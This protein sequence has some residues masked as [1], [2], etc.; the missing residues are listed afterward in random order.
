MCNGVDDDCDNIVDDGVAQLYWP[1]ADGD[2]FGD[3]LGA[4]VRGCVPPA[5]MVAAAGDCDD[6]D[7]TLAD[8]SC[9]TEIAGG[10]PTFG[11]DVGRTGHAAGFVG[12]GLLQPLWVVTLAGT[13]VEPAAIAG[14][15]VVV[16]ADGSTDTVHAI[17]IATGQPLWSS[18]IDA[19]SYPTAPTVDGD[20]V[21][22][23]RVNSG[24]SDLI[25]LDLVT[26]FEVW[27]TAFTVQW[28]QYWSPLVMGGRVFAAGGY[29]GG[30]YGWDATTGI[31]L[32]YEDTPWFDQWTPAGHDNIVYTHIDDALT[33]RDPLSG[34]ELW[35]V[36]LPEGSTSYS[37]MNTV[38][39]LADDLA[40]LVAGDDLVGVDLIGR[41]LSW[42][43]EGG[44]SGSPTLASGLVYA[45]RNGAVAQIDPA[46]G[47]VVRTFAGDGDL[48]GKPIVTDDVLIATSSTETF[49][50]RTWDGLVLDTLPQGGD[51]SVG[52][53]V[54][55]LVDGD[56]VR[57]YDWL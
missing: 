44:F 6:L 33:A 40:V 32:W 27:Q 9:P 22:L 48:A 31:E 10:W 53:G 17:E 37:E 57:A 25:R 50:F 49:V 15:L 36:V 2:G 23:Q 14:G 29:T 46:D 20:G 26:G 12:G 13:T 55:V 54:V 43:I 51:A 8:L 3:P 52:E 30:V 11:G 1:D 56:T 38:P 7:D 35:S 28:E 42:S 5:G 47:Y 24:D 4:F 16:L 21:Y 39:A 45:V 18:T 34:T 19:S 41:Q